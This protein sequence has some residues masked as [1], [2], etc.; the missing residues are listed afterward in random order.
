MTSSNCHASVESGDFRLLPAIAWASIYAD[1]GEKASQSCTTIQN[2]GALPATALARFWPQE[3]PRRLEDFHLLPSMCSNL[4]YRIPNDQSGKLE[5]QQVTT[6]EQLRVFPTGT[7]G[8]EATEKQKLQ[9]EVA[10]G[11]LGLFE[12]Y[13]ALT[14]VTADTAECIDDYQESREACIYSLFTSCFEDISKLGDDTGKPK[15]EASPSGSNCKGSCSTEYSEVDAHVLFE[16][17]EKLICDMGEP[18]KDSSSSELFTGHT[19]GKTPSVSQAMVEQTHLATLQAQKSLGYLASKAHKA[20]VQM[21]RSI[22]YMK[23][24]SESVLRMPE[25][26]QRYSVETAENAREKA[27]AVSATATQSVSQSSKKVLDMAMSM[28]AT[29]F[30]PPRGGA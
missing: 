22:E 11:G 16:D 28:R 14:A 20:K 4:A 13:P 15:G 25:Q 5:A 18:T 9:A 6:G 2:F 19:A 12:E 27:R 21:Q 10:S 24:Q 3:A 1:F 23:E 29:H 17:M 7:A 8:T 30:T 26:I